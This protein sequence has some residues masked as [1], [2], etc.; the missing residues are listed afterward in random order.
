[1]KNRVRVFIA[2]SVDGFIAGVNDDLSWLPGPESGEEE[3][4]PSSGCDPEAI[5][6]GEFFEGIGALLMGRRTYDVVRGF[7]G[8][9]PYGDTP[10]L[11]AKRRPLDADRPKTVTA[12][13]GPIVDV[14]D[15][16]YD[17]GPGHLG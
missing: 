11:V 16:V 8:P 10:V 9:W 15:V 17:S 4:L 14:I 13:G 5:E 12:V 3:A 1:M 7:D 2:A 6:F